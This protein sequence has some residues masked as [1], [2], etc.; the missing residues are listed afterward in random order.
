M[1]LLATLSALAALTCSAYAQV[2][3]C[4]TI[5]NPEERLACYDK[6]P[7]P[8]A[9]VPKRGHGTATPKYVD[10]TVNE[11]ERM[12]KLLKPVCKNC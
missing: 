3:G 6:A 5:L 9:A 10:E 1:K 7:S 8:P 12:K 4:K 2:P 11:D